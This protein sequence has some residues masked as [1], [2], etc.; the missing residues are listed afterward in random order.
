MVMQRFLAASSLR[1]ARRGLW[2]NGVFSV[3]ALGMLAIFGLAV[4]VYC[5]KSGLSA[6]V[7]PIAAVA[8]MLR[9]FPAW[10]SGLVGAGLLAATM[11]SIDSGLNSCSAAVTAD[12]LPHFPEWR[13]S[14]GKLTI[15]LA[16]PVM[17]FAGGL[18]PVLN[19]DNTLFVILNRSVNTMGTPLLAVMLAALFWKKVRASAVFYGLTGGFILTIAASVFIRGL[20]LH[21]Y[22]VLALLLTL[23]AMGIAQF[24]CIRHDAP[25]G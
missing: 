18:L 3:L 7:P 10:A 13:P 14:P 9:G 11:S 2:L 24:F 17:A 21:G 8:R 22:A 15:L 20:A 16:M 4:H 12:F 6:D 25:A 1:A 19:R 5:R 23:G